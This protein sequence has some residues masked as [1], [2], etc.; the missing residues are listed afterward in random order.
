MATGKWVCLKQTPMEN[1]C[2]LNSLCP[3]FTYQLSIEYMFLSYNIPDVQHGDIRIT[4]HV[5][6]LISL[7]SCVESDIYLCT[8]AKA[9]RSLPDTNRKFE[10]AVWPL[11]PKDVWTASVTSEYKHG[12]LTVLVTAVSNLLHRFPCLPGLRLS[13][14]SQ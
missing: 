5:W 4:N 12:E 7:F 11:L 9:P 10:A 6:I 2:S 1:V 14:C 3:K 13:D 8:E